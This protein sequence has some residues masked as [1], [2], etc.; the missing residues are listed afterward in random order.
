METR[1]ITQYLRSLHLARVLP[2]FSVFLPWCVWSKLLTPFYEPFRSRC[3]HSTVR[4]IPSSNA[5]SG[6][7]P[8]SRRARSAGYS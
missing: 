5:T 7:N 6:A 1:F 8:N 2:L 3:H 4:A